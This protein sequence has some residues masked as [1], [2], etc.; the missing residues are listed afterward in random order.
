[1]RKSLIIT[2]TLAA[3]VLSLGM[4]WFVGL[5]QEEKFRKVDRP[6]KNRYI[7]VLE[8]SAAGELGFNSN[9]EYLAYD[10]AGTYGG[11]IDHVY[12]WAIHGFAVEL[13]PKQV[14]EMMLDARVKYIEEDG[15]ISIGATQTGATW[16]LDR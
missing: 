8:E 16:G 10:L 4:V 11:K 15:E 5:A 7:V 2:L 6:I 13:A 1:M 12:K 9:A 3:T 14:A